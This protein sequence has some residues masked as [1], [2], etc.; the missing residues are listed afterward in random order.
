M[1]VKIKYD[2]GHTRETEYIKSEVFCPNCGEKEVYNENDV[3]DVYEGV[4]H[5]CVRCCYEFK[6]PTLGKTD[7]YGMQVIIQLINR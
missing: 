7:N 5:L 3:G 1:K 4:T 2:A 6:L